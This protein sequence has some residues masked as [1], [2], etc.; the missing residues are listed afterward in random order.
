M[1]IQI[2]CWSW[3]PSAT[4][5][6]KQKRALLQDL[7]TVFN[8]PVKTIMAS[9]YEF[10]KRVPRLIVRESRIKQIEDKTDAALRVDS[11]KS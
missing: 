2:E 9:Q 6:I 1:N 7:P 5:K 11:G 10:Y 4:S 8:V 3:F